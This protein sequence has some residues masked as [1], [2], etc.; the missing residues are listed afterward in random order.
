MDYALQA[1]KSGQLPADFKIPDDA[2]G[3]KDVKEQDDKMDSDT[4]NEAEV[5]PKNVE[6]KGNDE[7]APMEEVSVY[8][9]L[10]TSI[11]LSTLYVLVILF[12]YFQFCCEFQNNHASGVYL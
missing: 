9:V 11:Q 10:G 12:S 8:M 2:T 6:E 7:S 1:L 4:P 5:D 3:T